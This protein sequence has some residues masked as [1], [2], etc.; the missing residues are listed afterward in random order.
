[1]Q[2]PCDSLVAFTNEVIV[3]EDE[4][5]TITDE[6]IYYELPEL[7]LNYPWCEI[8]YKYKVFDDQSTEITD[9]V[10][11]DLVESDKH[12]LKLGPIDGLAVL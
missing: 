5:Y 12:V 9:P 6:E 4:E 1:M 10:W 11:V 3:L 7:T 2:D 8:R